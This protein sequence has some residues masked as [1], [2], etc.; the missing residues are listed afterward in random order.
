[1]DLYA[2]KVKTLII[3][4]QR[5]NF[6]FQI[7]QFYLEII[8]MTKI[9]RIMYKKTLIWTGIVLYKTRENIKKTKVKKSKIILLYDFVKICFYVLKI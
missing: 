7:I 6:I 5:S 3:V 9:F 8:L 4:N 2:L 1:M